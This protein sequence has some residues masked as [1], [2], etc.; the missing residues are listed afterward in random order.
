MNDLARPT[1]FGAGT[2]GLCHAE[3]R[4][5][6]RADLAAAA[7]VRTDLR[8]GP[9]G[10]AGAVAVGAGFDPRDVQLFLTAESRF[11]K[12]DVQ[13]RTYIVSA[14]RGIWVPCLAAAA[15]AE[16]V[17]ETGE[18]IAEVS[19]TAAKTAET[20]AETCVGVKGRMTVL[21]VLLPLFLIGEDFRPEGGI[22]FVC[23][24]CEEGLGNLLG[25]R[26]I[27]ADFAG[28]I[29]RQIS[30]DACIGEVCDRCVGSH[31]YEVTVTT[32]GGH[33]FSS[34]G[35]KNA[36]AEASKIISRIYGLKVPEK[37][38]TKT[39]Y[40]V[41]TF[42]GGTS[43]NSI[44]EEA[45]FLCEYR[46]D[47][48]LCMETVKKAFEEI[49]EEAR[50]DDV[51]VSVK[52]VGDRPCAGDADR[53]EI[54][55]MADLYCRLSQEMTGAAAVRQSASTDCNIPLS[56]GIP[57][58]C[59]GAMTSGG[60]HTTGEWLKKESLIDGTRLFIRFLSELL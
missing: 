59:V 8:C 44:A 38:G 56:L 28:R 26:R 37:E 12:T 55:R 40:N 13:L 11:F 57:A 24:S 9:G 14:A 32:P 5:L 46:S 60:A 42:S 47:D 49:F 54:A 29:A 15:E 18:D 2:H 7:A 39:T 4:A 21:V 3:R 48:A 53:E 20:A 25:I 45:S 27:H 51:G 35:K 6:G 34:F 52:Q 33:S 22:L 31:R 1:A 23:N 17:A 43:V 50:G 30:V 41:G 58:V 10:A 36:I 19:E 16:N